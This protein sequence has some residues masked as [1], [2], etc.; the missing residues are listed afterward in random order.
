[1][2]P[3]DAEIARAFAAR[4]PGLAAWARFWFYTPALDAMSDNA[5]ARWVTLLLIAT[6]AWGAFVCWWLNL[7][8]G[9]ELGFMVWGSMTSGSLSLALWA[10]S[11]RRP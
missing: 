10:P 7:I 4:Y 3:K 1:M 6:F 5:L 11:L 9:G 8:E 2:K